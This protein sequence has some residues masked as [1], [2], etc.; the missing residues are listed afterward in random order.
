MKE[1]VIL[2]PNK[3]KLLKKFSKIENFAINLFQ[4]KEKI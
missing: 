3:E 4:N 1:K 2:N